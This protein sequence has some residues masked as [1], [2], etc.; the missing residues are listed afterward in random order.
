MTTA[1]VAEGGGVDAARLRKHLRRKLNYADLQRIVIEVPLI[2]DKRRSKAMEI[3]AVA[4][5]VKSVAIQ[6]E[7]ADQLVII[8]EG[9][10]AAKVTKRLRRKLKYADLVSVEQVEGTAEN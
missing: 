1:S 2:S 7:D 3:A 6:K 5:G 4:K 9:V 8:G 10:D